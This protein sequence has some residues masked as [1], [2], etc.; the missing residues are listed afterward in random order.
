LKELIPAESNPYKYKLLP[1]VASVFDAN[2]KLNAEVLF[3]VHFE[4]TIPGQGH[5]ITNYLNTPVL[6]PILL[7]GYEPTD[8]RRDLLNSQAVDVNAKIIKKFYDTYDA[9]NRTM[10]YDFII[11]RYADVLLM[12]AEAMNEVAYSGETASDQFKYLN[13]VRSRAKASLYTPASLSSQTA[14]RE[15]VLQERRLELPFEFSRWFDLIRTGTA[16]K[17]LQNSGLTKIAIQQF[18]Y[19]Y[20]VPQGQIE[21]MHNPS[22]FPQNTGY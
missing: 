13:L 9:I 6:D 16:T 4:K 19:L 12:Y 1:D 3:A 2:N 11:L 17:A 10:G 18:Q 7:A 8:T 21:V 14:F 15:A 22:I 5:G 20:P